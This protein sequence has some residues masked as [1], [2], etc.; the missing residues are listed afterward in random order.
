MDHMAMNGVIHLDERLDKH[1]QLTLGN[2]YAMHTYG[3]KFL[4]KVT[5]QKI[6][7]QELVASGPFMQN[8]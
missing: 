4:V 8:S 3:L 5:G 1:P 7:G 2:H 6:T